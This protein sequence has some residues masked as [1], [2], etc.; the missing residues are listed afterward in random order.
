MFRAWCRRMAWRWCMSW[1]IYGFLMLRPRA[2]R[3]PYTSVRGSR[4]WTCDFRSAVWR[5]GDMSFLSSISVKVVAM[6]GYSI[7]FIM[8]LF[9]QYQASPGCMRFV[10]RASHHLAIFPFRYSSS[11]FIC[12][13]GRRWMPRASSAW[14]TSLRLMVWDPFL[15]VKSPGR[16]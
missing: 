1:V 16:S 4:L 2:R 13:S 3:E 9:R 12:P 5:R 8:V 10:R 15:S 11:C 6:S 7:V 14:C